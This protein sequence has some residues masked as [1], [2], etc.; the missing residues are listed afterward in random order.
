MSY[1]ANRPT[2]NCYW[3]HVKK[4]YFNKIWADLY[5]QWTQKGIKM[6]ELLLG[7]YQYKYMEMECSQRWSD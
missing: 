4:I 7:L 3:P 6:K 2:S 5:Q 1:E